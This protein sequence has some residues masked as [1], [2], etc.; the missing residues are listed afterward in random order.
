MSTTITGFWKV[1]SLIVIVAFVVLVA[2]FVYH[3]TRIPQNQGE[4]L[5]RMIELQKEGRYDKAVQVVQN[6]MND[7]RRDISH[8]GFMYGQIAMVY[9]MK[10]YK[11][12]TARD[13]SVRRAEENLQKALSFFDG[14][15]QS[16]LS[17]D[18]FEIGGGYEI[19]ADISDKDKCRLYEKARALFARQLPLIKGDSYTA[20]GHT[21]QLEPVRGDVRKH[22]IA[23]IEK[24]SKARC[25]AYSEKLNE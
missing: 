3:E 2:R 13:Q 18:P 5:N 1:L 6:W 19:L 16:D 15:S 10:A 12:P 20:Y 23:V 22:L 8:D 7:G 17:L 21:T 14:R 11:R 24:S 4:V 9:I 25:P